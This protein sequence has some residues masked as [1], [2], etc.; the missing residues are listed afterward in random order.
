MKTRENLIK[1]A[2]INRG[3]IKRLRNELDQTKLRNERLLMHSKRIIKKYITPTAS[4]IMNDRAS[5]V[6]SERISGQRG[7][8]DIGK[9]C[10][11]TRERVR[12]I[13]E[14]A[15]IDYF[16]FIQSIGLSDATLVDNISLAKFSRRTE[17]CLLNGGISTITQLKAAG[18]R[19][20]RQLRG[21]GASIDN[22]VQSYLLG[23]KSIDTSVFNV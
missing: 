6:F 18:L 16:K 21:F 19:E 15:N 1:E 12:Q 22:E 2:C 10:G 14:K 20:L 8:E 13:D 9:E 3:E 5:F 11:V 23:K 17:N 4:L 7:L